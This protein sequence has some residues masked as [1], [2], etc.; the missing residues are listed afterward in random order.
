MVVWVGFCPMTRRGESGE[1]ED[2]IAMTK[3]EI[4]CWMVK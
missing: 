3:E 1:L 4:A 2:I